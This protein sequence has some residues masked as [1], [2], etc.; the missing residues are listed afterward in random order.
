MNCFETWNVKNIKKKSSFSTTMKSLKEIIS[1]LLRFFR[2]IITSL[3][4]EN[5]SSNRHANDSYHEQQKATR[6]IIIFFILCFIHKFIK[7]NLWI[8]NWDFQLH[9]HETKRRVIQTLNHVELSMSYKRVLK[10]FN[11]LHA[12]QKENLKNL[13]QTRKFLMTWNNLKQIKRVKNQRLNNKIKFL[14]VITTQILSS[15]WMLEN[16]LK[17]SM[18]NQSISLNYRKIL[19][20]KI[21]KRDFKMFKKICLTKKHCLIF[22]YNE[23]NVELFYSWRHTNHL[24]N[25]DEKK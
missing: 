1:Q 21:F 3:R 15:I 24:Q 6:W 25:R 20:H 19:S 23:L 2:F 9:A 17:Q 8:V 12:N 18:L 7:C 10:L 22:A 5:E 11:F 14:S 16:E 4:E 13:N